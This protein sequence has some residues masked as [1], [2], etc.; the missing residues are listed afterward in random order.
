MMSFSDSP[1]NTNGRFALVTQNEHAGYLWITSILSLIYTSLT[2]IVRLHI[3]W[4]LYGADDVLASAATVLQL[5]S[6]IPLFLAMK[7]GLGKSDQLLNDYSIA[8]IGKS[9]FAAQIFLLVAITTA[10]GSVATLMLR[11]FT[12]DMKVTRKSWISCNAT[13]AFIVAWGVGA[14]VALTLSCNPSGYLKNTRGQCGYQVTRWKIITA[15]D[16]SLELLLAVLP[17]FFIWPIQMKRYIKLQVVFAFGF[18]LPAVGF[19]AAHLHFVSK[20]AR[21]ND[22]S[23][24]MIAALVYQQ[25][26]LFWLLLA[27]TVPTMKAFMRSFNSGFGMEIDL[28]GYGSGYGSG[29]YSNRSY[30]LRSLQSATGASGAVIG[31]KRSRPSD[32]Y[33]TAFPAPTPRREV[34]CMDSSVRPSMTSDSSQEL[35]IQKHVQVSVYHEDARQV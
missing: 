5:G 35:I 8:A 34:G 2:L 29:G 25:F 7:Q 30:P 3:K 33:H 18:R 10:K 6:V 23:H 14:I 15:F 4:N 19:S 1:M 9:T 17:I 31:G 11:L 32:G 21:N 27:A 16:I 24:D 13:L 20:S 28:D 22:T 12:R 26:E